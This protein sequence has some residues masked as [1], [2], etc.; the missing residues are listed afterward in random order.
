M[1][2][3]PGEWTP[4]RAT[5]EINA[6]ARSEGLTLSWKYH[7]K[8]Q[9]LARDISMGDVLH[10]LR[11]G[12]VYGPP[13]NATRAGYHKYIVETTTPNSEGRAVGVVVISDGACEL[14]IITV[15]WRDEL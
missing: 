13:R 11:R 8:E 4:A 5:K 7:A 6:C 10:V 1:A 12:F 15:M 14:K 2:K 9:M 3:A